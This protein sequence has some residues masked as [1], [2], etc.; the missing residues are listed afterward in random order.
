MHFV[1]FTPTWIGPRVI[2]DPI[3]RFC[4]IDLSEAALTV[5][6]LPPDP[7]YDYF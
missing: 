7:D 1:T 5:N 3:L 2:I 6:S 4:H